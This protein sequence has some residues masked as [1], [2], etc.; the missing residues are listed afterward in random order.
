MQGLVGG[1][2]H[3]PYRLFVRHELDGVSVKVSYHGPGLLGDIDAG[4]DI[5]EGL[6]RGKVAVDPLWDAMNAL[7]GN[8]IRL[9][10]P[11][12][13]PTR[14]VATG[15][16]D[17]YPSLWQS[18]AHKA[19]LLATNMGDGPAEGTIEMTLSELDL[20][21]KARIRPLAIDGTYP[22]VDVA[23]DTVRISGIPP[24]SFTACLIE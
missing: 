15:A 3:V 19:L 2:H 9:H 13:I 5:Y 10:N 8:V 7:P 17:L 23:D 21:D 4:E 14:A 6:F 18:D 20:P 22:D 16:A 11:A 24:L 12:Y 1:S